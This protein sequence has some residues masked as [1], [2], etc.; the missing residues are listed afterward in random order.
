MRTVRYLALG[1]VLAGYITIVLGG[2]VS[3]I[4]AGLACP[5]WPTCH[6]QLIPDL[7]DPLVAAEYVHR[8]AAALAGALALGTLVLVWVSHRDNTR[9]LIATNIAFGLLV[10]QILLGWITVASYLEPMIVTGHL[11]VAAAFILVMTVVAISAYRET[12][13]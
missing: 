6:G 2:Y 4:G 12:A 1:T 10:V 5:D 13:E 11:A 9:L 7:A 3:S 8:L